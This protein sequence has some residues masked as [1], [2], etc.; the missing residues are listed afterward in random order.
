MPS[1]PSEDLGQP[2]H[3]YNKIILPL[4][5]E[6]KPST[7][8]F[9]MKTAKTDETVWIGRLIRVFSGCLSDFVCFVV[10][11][12]MERFAIVVEKILTLHCADIHFF[13]S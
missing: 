8:C 13:I 5:L 4:A 3:P 11:R 2:A 12:L 10:L 7:Q 1:A 9:F 6:G